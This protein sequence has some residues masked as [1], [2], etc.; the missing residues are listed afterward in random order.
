MNNWIEQNKEKFSSGTNEFG[1]SGYIEALPVYKL[2]QLFSKD[3]EQLAREM[4]P[5]VSLTDAFNLAR[6][7]GFLEA[8]NLQQVKIEAL[9]KERDAYY[10]QLHAKRIEVEELREQIAFLEN[11]IDE[12]D[13]YTL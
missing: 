13:K 10:D 9:K 7:E 3:G 4:Y 2:K 5:V 11:E 12:N 1:E 6:R 8:Y